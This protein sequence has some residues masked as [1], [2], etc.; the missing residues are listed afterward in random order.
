MRVL[1]T[2]IAFDL[3]SNLATEDDLATFSTLL[4]CVA[5]SSDK[6]NSGFVREL[7]K[8]MLSLFKERG[9]TVNTEQ[10]CLN[11]EL[12]FIQLATLKWWN[13]PSYVR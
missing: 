1:T 9:E 4:N 10:G 5:S 8:S 6:R 11:L 3:L 2:F 12:F 7:L 13:K